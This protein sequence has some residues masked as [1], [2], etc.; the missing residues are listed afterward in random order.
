MIPPPDSPAALAVRV[1]SA[2]AGVEKLWG[3]KAS[4][5]EV[6][7][8][9]EEVRTRA[10]KDEVAA[11]VRGQDELARKVDRLVMVLIVAAVSFA[12]SAIT[13]ALTASRIAGGGT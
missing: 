3:A 4:A 7:R 1:A 8:L 9:D 2:E 10:T 5:R 11:V 6:E 12:G 13:F